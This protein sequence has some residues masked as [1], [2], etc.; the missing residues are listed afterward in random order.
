MALLDELAEALATEVMEAQ[1]ELGPKADRLFM[2]V[3]NHIGTSSPSFQE[4]FM[5]ACRLHMA[6]DRGRE[7]FEAR[8]KAL[9]ET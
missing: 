8:L 2:E 4:A 6:A 7:F 1:K 5:T 9:K 3:G